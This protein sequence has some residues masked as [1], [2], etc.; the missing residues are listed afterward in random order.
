[1]LWSLKSCFA[2]LLLHNS[3]TAHTFTGWQSFTCCCLI[4]VVDF[5]PIKES[6]CLVFPCCI[7]AISTALDLKNASP[8]FLSLHWWWLTLQHTLQKSPLMHPRERGRERERDREREREERDMF[9]FTA[10]THT[11]YLFMCPDL[12]ALPVYRNT[13]THQYSLWFPCRMEMQLVFFALLNPW[14]CSAF[15]RATDSL[16]CNRGASGVH[17]HSS[18]A[19]NTCK[20]GEITKSPRLRSLF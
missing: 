1:M 15:I 3:E 18:D 4:F 9:F 12:P 5:N 10:L 14:V 20:K 11:Q 6:G 17:L 19:F 13:C 2:D 7:A 16:I 8:L